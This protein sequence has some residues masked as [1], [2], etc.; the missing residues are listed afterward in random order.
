LSVAKVLQTF[1]KVGHSCIGGGCGS[2]PM[3]HRLL[4]FLAGYIYEDVK[5]SL[6]PGL[7]GGYRTCGQISC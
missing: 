7:A 6:A 2:N 3:G 4:P 5:E 1:L